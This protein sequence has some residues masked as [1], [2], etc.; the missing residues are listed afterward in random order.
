MLAAALGCLLHLAV[1]APLAGEPSVIL[2]RDFGPDAEAILNGARPYGDLDF[3]YPPLAL[4]LTVAP[5]AVSEGEEGYRRAFA[6]QM[7]GFDLAIVV[8][9]ALG[10]RARPRRVWGALAIYSAAIFALSGIV[11]PESV[12]DR[13]LPLARFDLAPAAL[14]L[15]AVLA[16]EAGRSASWSALLSA[17]TAVKAF[18]A[19]LY[20]AVLRGERAIG[21][22]VAGAVPALLLAVAV[23]VV[24][25]DRFESAISYHA[26]RDLHVESVAASPVIGA[27]M[28]GAEAAIDHGAGSYN[29]KAPGAGIARAVSIM[30]LVVGLLAVTW[31]GWRSRTSALHA[32]VAVL[33]VTVVFA[34]VLSPQFLLWVLPLSAAA[35]GLRAANIVLL[36]AVVL[37]AVMLHNY[38]GV[39]AL[40]P[41]FTWAALARNA[42]LIAYGALVVAPVLSGGVSGRASV[43]DR[44][45][46][47][48]RRCGSQTA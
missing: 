25:G 3:E 27:H 26:G 1:L 38:P 20:P 39:E 16:R 8:L 15:A 33:A 7:L 13:S 32:A 35:Y 14:V 46:P 47:G 28:L 11:A 23:L 41:R 30:L 44:G 36:G 4:A 37:T 5:G 34:P 31:A 22:V 48:L 19:V 12:L 45:T 18:P 10:L 40:E 6:W 21:R 2:D 9:L 17:A 42:A 24:L 29:V 43:A